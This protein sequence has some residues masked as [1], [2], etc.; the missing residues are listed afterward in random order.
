MQVPLVRKVA[1]E[2]E[3]EQT[4]GVLEVYVTGR[5][6]V[7]VPVSVSVACACTLDGRV[8]VMVCEAA[9]TVVDADTGVAAA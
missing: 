8:K 5:P 2:P 7:A 1:V 6:E 3:T 9:V 4:V